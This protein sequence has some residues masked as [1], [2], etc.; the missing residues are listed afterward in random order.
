MLNDN[1]VWIP[2]S[3]VALLVVFNVFLLIK[4]I[5]PNKFFTKPKKIWLSILLILVPFWGLVIFTVMKDYKR[6]RKNFF[7]HLF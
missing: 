1:F 4:E 2:F 3:V 6:H 7:F 5:W